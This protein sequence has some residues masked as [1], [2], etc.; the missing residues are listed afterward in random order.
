MNEY[1]YR[2]KEISEKFKR[3]FVDSQDLKEAAESISDL[4]ICRLISR[5]GRYEWEDLEEG[6]VFTIQIKRS[7]DGDVHEFDVEAKINYS[8]TLIEVIR[9][10]ESDG[11]ERNVKGL[12][13]CNE[14]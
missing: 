13:N 9:G 2:I 12:I 11:S 6:I 10:P 4:N 1:W 14:L 7:K 8:A 3:D 5:D